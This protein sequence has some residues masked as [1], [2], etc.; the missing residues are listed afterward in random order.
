MI[1]PLYKA[2]STQRNIEQVVLALTTARN[3][4]EQENIPYISFKDIAKDNRKALETGKELITNQYQHPDIPIEE[5][6]AY[7]GLSYL[8]L[9]DE[10][11]EEDAKKLFSQ[12]GRKVFF[13]KKTFT[14]ILKKLTPDLL[15]ATNSPRSERAA[16]ESARSL[17]IPSIC[18]V[19]L[20]TESDLRGFLSEPG[21]ASKVCVLNEFTK[22]KLIE[23]G[24]PSDEIII[25]GNPAFD[26]LNLKEHIDAAA[27]YRNQHNLQKQT[28]ILWAS[29]TLPTDVELANHTENKLIELAL[30]N[31]HFTVIIRPHPNEPPRKIPNAP[32]ILL[33][34]KDD[35]IAKILHAVDVVCTLYSTVAVEA[36]LVGKTV[37]QMTET[38][39]FKSFNC[40]EAGFAHGASDMI[41]LENIINQTA[42]SKNT[43]STIIPNLNA[44]SKVIDVMMKFIHS[45]KQ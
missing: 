31:P 33:S 35:H 4:F 28:T 17:G 1:A 7:M 10:L 12:E 45:E 18:L 8:D 23:A 34:S 27:A 41:E 11:G 38:D 40:V 3:T 30:K 16:I 2:V 43:R 14:D 36:H 20:F 15:I 25:T 5:S 24:R 13:P 19:D 44:T 42:I 29:S 6:I 22:K 21:Y 32:N 9:V 26:A 39:M 37:I